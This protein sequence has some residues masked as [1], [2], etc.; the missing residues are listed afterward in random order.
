MDAD[1]R[2]EAEI[3]TLLARDDTASVI[4]ALMSMPRTDGDPNGT[5][6]KVLHARLQ[7]RLSRRMRDVLEG[8]QENKDTRS[9][10]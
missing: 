7:E 3:D 4:D 9:A 8:R 10:A 5:W 6:E 2:I 1:D